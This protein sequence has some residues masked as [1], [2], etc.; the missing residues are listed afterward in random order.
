ML[1]SS[2]AALVFAFKAKF[3]S[4]IFHMVRLPGD[5]KV[6]EGQASPKKA[7]NRGINVDPCWPSAQE[8][9]PLP[10]LGGAGPWA[11]RSSSPSPSSLN[12]PGPLSVPLIPST[13]GA[14]SQ[15]QALRCDSRLPFPNLAGTGSE[16]DF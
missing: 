1:V 9:K 12:T 2:R 10:Q 11:R 16:G 5:N 4:M 7:D 15:V 6:L 8:P 14:G 3:L 13:A